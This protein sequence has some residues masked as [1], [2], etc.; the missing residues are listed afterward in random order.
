MQKIKLSVVLAVKNEE[1]NL[2]RCLLGIKEIAD[3]IVIVDEFSKDD[4]LKIAKKFE[5][6]I[7]QRKVINNFH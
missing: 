5:A 4:T 6:R 3:E 2:E 1:S 7:F